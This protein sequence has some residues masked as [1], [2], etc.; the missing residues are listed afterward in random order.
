MESKPVFGDP[1][2]DEGVLYMVVGGQLG[3]VHD[4]SSGA[5]GGRPVPEAKDA[6][7]MVDFGGVGKE[8]AG[9]AFLRLHADFDE[10]SGVRDYRSY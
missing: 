7:S 10:V 1:Q 8:G 3:G 4:D 9:V 6:A 5:G 2:V